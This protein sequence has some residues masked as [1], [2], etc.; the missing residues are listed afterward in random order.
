MEIDEIAAPARGKKDDEAQRKRVY[1]ID[2]A[3]AGY[4]SCSCCQACVAMAAVIR[5][6]VQ[7]SKL[8]GEGEQGIFV[9]FR[10]GKPAEFVATHSPATRAYAAALSS[11]TFSHVLSTMEERMKKAKRASDLP[12]SALRITIRNIF[13][14][15]AR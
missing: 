9:R 11:D 4:V 7:V 10:G 8:G 2:T 15:Y 5:S 13:G 12:C 3:I 1:R 6:V 14:E